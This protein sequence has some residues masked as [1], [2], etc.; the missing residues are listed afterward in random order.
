MDNKEKIE[1]LKKDIEAYKNTIWAY[2]F[3]FH[4]LE[5]AHR[6]EVIEAFEKKIELAEA[7]IKAIDLRK[8]L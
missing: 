3:E 7:K 4:D 2:K 6:Q 8:N 5:D 1:K